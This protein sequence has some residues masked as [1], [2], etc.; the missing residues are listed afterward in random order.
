MTDRVA[1]K[2]A[3]NFEDVP[4]NL[5]SYLRR[6]R[7]P[8]GWLVVLIDNVRT[9]YDGRFSY[10]EEYRSSIAFVQDPEWT[11]DLSVNGEVTE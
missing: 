3:L 8:G 10:G 4:T 7:V 6:A 5:G 9:L 1:A 2:A 11:W